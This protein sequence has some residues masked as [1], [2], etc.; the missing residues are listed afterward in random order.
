MLRAV[1]G[2]CNQW[3]FTDYIFIICH[4]I[5]W[6]FYFLPRAFL[7]F[8]IFYH[9]HFY[10]LAFLPPAF[11]PFGIF[12]YWHYYRLAF[13]PLTFSLSSTLTNGIFTIRHFYQWHFYHEWLIRME[14]LKLCVYTCSMIRGFLHSDRAHHS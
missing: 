6:H 1:F 9:R 14:N 8:S 4:F 3:L 12:T 13:L 11:L 5:T 7:P 2:L 10:H